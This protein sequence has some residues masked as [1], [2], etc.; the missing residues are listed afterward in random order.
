MFSCVR[1]LSC[2]ESLVIS[3]VLLL[4]FG[5]GGAGEGHSY[6]ILSSSRN[7]MLLQKLDTLL[8]YIPL[9]IPCPH[10]MVC[11]L[12]YTNFCYRNRHNHT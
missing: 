8:C 3:C 5:G 6:S 1:L 11:H 12:E 2:I 10:S 4:G 9:L 7:S